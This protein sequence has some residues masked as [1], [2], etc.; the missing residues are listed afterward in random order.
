MATDSAR[1]WLLKAGLSI[2][3]MLVLLPVMAQRQ[4]GQDD[5]PTLNQQE[6]AFLDSLLNVQQQYLLQLRAQNEPVTLQETVDLSN[7]RVAF[8]TGSLG[9][10]LLTKSAFF[11]NNILPWTEKGEVPVVNTIALSPAERTAS[12]GY[13]VVILVWTKAFPK[14]SR[15]KVLAQLAAQSSR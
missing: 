5:Q 2:S 1:H 10:S 4:L 13:D 9:T 3:L 11:R 6:V 12:G 14:A 8:A 7:K 15:R